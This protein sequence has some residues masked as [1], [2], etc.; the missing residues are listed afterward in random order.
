MLARDTGAPGIIA[1]PMCPAIRQS[2]C[3]VAIVACCNGCC[4]RGGREDGAWNTCWWCIRGCRHCSRQRCNL[5]Q[6]ELHFVWIRPQIRKWRFHMVGAMISGHA[7]VEQE[8]AIPV[9]SLE[10]NLELRE[11]LVNVRLVAP[12]PAFQLKKASFEDDRVS[13][14]RRTKR[15]ADGASPPSVAN[16][17]PARSCS[18]SSSIGVGGFQSVAMRS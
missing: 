13:Y 14:Y 1:G 17:N 7:S 6:E 9:P 12:F 4:C 3:S 10:V 16:A 15:G 2:S 8:Q 11:G 18:K 5:V